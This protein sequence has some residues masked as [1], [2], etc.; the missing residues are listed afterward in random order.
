MG[1]RNGS[2]GAGSGGLALAHGLGDQLPGERTERDAPHAVAAGDDDAAAAAWSA[3]RVCWQETQAAAKGRNS[4]R[5][6][7]TALPQCT[8]VP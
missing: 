6:A 3:Q 5:S 1:Q 8:H 7:G 4:S 2:N